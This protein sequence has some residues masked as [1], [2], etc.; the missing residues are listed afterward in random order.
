MLKRITILLTLAAALAVVAGAPAAQRQPEAGTMV[1]YLLS[2]QSGAPLEGADVRLV[3]TLKQQGEI[4][5]GQLRFL[6]RPQ[7][8]GTYSLDGIHAG[9]YVIQV[10]AQGHAPM[11]REV[12]VRAGEG[13]REVFQLPESGRL[14]GVVCIGESQISVRQG[15]SFLVPDDLP[16][17]PNL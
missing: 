8:M 10:M 11:L 1:A 12:N 17:P 3:A 6:M 15:L 16:S 5:G 4:G 7:G 2:E 14:Q 9:E 13:Q